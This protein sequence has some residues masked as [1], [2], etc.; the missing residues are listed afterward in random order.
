[1]SKKPNYPPMKA[2]DYGCLAG[3]GFG[4]VVAGLLAVLV[5][6]ILVVAVKATWGYL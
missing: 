3:L 1:M 5:V 6:L 2:G 4:V